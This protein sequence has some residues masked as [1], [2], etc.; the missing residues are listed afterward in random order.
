MRKDRLLDTVLLNYLG[1]D[2]F[3][4][5]EIRSLAQKLRVHESKAREH[6]AKEVGR[7]RL[8]AF[9]G[10]PDATQ[11]RREQVRSGG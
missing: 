7:G 4:G 10:G 9:S 6:V 5:S 3:N 11:R 2:R 1:A 8:S